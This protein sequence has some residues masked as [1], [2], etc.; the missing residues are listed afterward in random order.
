MDVNGVDLT[1]HTVFEVFLWGGLAHANPRKK[2]IYDS[3]AQNPAFLLL[4]Q[5]KFVHAL[6]II[7]N[8]IF[9]ARAINKAALTQLALKP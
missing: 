5:D 4:L 9:F 1:Y 7:L 3:W 2:A 6:K 8:M